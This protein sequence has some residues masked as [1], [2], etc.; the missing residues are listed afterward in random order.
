MWQIR[1]EYDGSRHDSPL[2]SF[3]LINC[4]KPTR[5]VN[6]GVGTAV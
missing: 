6:L 2:A 3:K 5:L 4:S 1:Y